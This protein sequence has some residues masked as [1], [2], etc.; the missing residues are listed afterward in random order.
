[1]RRH[2]LERFVPLRESPRPEQNKFAS[3]MSR[4]GFVIL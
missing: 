3:R 1:M 4:I 2:F